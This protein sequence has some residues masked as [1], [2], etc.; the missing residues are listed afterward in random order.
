MKATENCAR[1]RSANEFG[2]RTSLCK[3]GIYWGVPKCFRKRC[4]V[5]SASVLDILRHYL[6][7]NIW[8]LERK[9]K[10]KQSD[11]YYH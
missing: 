11:R 9:T 7:K 6:L 1:L 3:W 4:V 10:C 8:R 5:A 2:I